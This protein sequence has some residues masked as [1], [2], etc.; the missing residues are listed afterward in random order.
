MKNISLNIVFAL[1][2]LFGVIIL[3]ASSTIPVAPTT[4]VMVPATPKEVLVLS[5]GDKPNTEITVKNSIV[6][7]TRQGWI[8]KTV[9]ITYTGYYPSGIIVL[10][11]Y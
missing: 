1:I 9:T 8:L 7:Y 3:I 6:K 4:T 10:E 5:F 11:K 2:F